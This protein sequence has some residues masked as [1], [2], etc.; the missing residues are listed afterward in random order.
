MNYLKL[1]G[2]V[3]LLSMSQLNS[4]KSLDVGIGYLGAEMKSSGIHLELSYNPGQ[5]EKFSLPVNLTSS[6]ASLEDYNS[7]TIDLQKGFRVFLAKDFYFEQFIGVGLIGNNYKNVDLWYYDE[8]INVTIPTDG[9]NFSF[10]PSLSLGVGYQI[11]PKT[12]VWARQKTFWNLGFRGLH[13]PYFSY[14]IGFSYQL[15]TF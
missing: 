7:L 1:I 3:L 12:R 8:F 14:Q 10:S 4:Q 9:Y 2:A 13:L 15:K 6:F 5:S 11:S